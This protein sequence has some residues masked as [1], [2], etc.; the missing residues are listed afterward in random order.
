[1]EKALLAE[2]VDA[3]KI[4]Q[5]YLDDSPLLFSAIKKTLAARLAAMNHQDL[6]TLK[7]A[8]SGIV[9]E[10]LLPKPNRQYAKALLAFITNKKMDGYDVDSYLTP[11]ITK[12]VED[13]FIAF[14]SEEKR[15]NGV[16]ADIEE[17]LNE[18]RKE[19]ELHSALYDHLDLQTAVELREQNTQASEMTKFVLSQLS[20]ETMLGV[21]KQVAA[22]LGK[23]SYKAVI[24]NMGKAVFS[25]GMVSFIKPIVLGVLA[26]AGIAA[27]AKSAVAKALAV[28][29]GIGSIAASVP[30]AYVLLPVVIA[31]LS[32]EIYTLPKKLGVKLPQE[33]SRKL[34]AD[35][36]GINRRIT[37]EMVDGF[38]NELE[39][40]L[41]KEA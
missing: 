8:E 36:E 28:I 14:Y 12:V 27:V 35:F 34:E 5:L 22:I 20:T 24:V 38:L 11:L 25:S 31:F 13:E 30:V 15:L 32:Y 33:I 4:S 16:L 26:K 7:L 39:S 17:G 1:M 23:A 2:L 19:Y 41:L 37:T 29:I 10:T 6:L 40:K 21:F 18:I 9:R 3:E